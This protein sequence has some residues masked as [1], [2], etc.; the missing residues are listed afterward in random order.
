MPVHAVARRAALLLVAV[1]FLAAVSAPFAAEVD[2]SGLAVALTT[3][4]AVYAPG[5]PVRMV[6]EVTN[7]SKTPIVLDFA[8][9]QRFDVLISD[10]GGAEVWR[11][12]ARRMF[13]AVL[14]RET[15][16]SDN[17]RIVYEARVA[18]GLDPGAYRIR[19]WITGTTPH[20][21][22]SLGIRVR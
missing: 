11:W 12:S 5:E 3:D 2:R 4:K 10:E 14:G 1:C 8:S 21:S 17:P 7:R 15:L 20:F 18:R 22:A 16:E 9:A 6:L 19:A 13:A